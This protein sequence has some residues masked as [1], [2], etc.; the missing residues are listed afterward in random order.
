MQPDSGPSAVDIDLADRGSSDH[1]PGRGG[2]EVAR[3]IAIDVAQARAPEAELRPGLRERRLQRAQQGSAA[4]TEDVQTP[5]IG[6][7]AAVGVIAVVVAARDQDVPRTIAIDVRE[8]AQ[9]LTK[10]EFACG[11]GDGMV[12]TS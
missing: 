5:G 12:T 1:L 10:F 2:D 6:E 3:S 8:R 11:C 9:A 7:N 4:A